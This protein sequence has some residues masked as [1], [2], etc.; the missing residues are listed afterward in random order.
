VAVV[1]SKSDEAVSDFAAWQLIGLSRT[2]GPF[3]FSAVHFP[4]SMQIEHDM[5]DP[6]NQNQRTDIVYPS[7]SEC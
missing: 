2:R 6:T 5:I 7:L 3:K 4:K 1:T